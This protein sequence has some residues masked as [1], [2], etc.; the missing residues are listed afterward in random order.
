MQYSLAQI[1]I[2]PT[3][4]QSLP[5]KESEAITRKDSSEKIMKK[6]ILVFPCGSEIALEIHRSLKYSTYF[7]LIGGN[8]IDDHGRFVFENYIGDIPFITDSRFIPVIKEIVK[9]NNIAAIY[10]AMDAVIV[11]LKKYETDIGCKIISSDIETVELCLSKRKT[12]EKLKDIIKVPE[13]YHHAQVKKFPVFGKPD[14]GYG[15]RGTKK[16]DSQESLKDYIKNNKSALLCEFL[17]GEEYTV[18]CFTDKNGKLLFYAPRIRQR[19]MNGI[20]V[21]TIPYS[22]KI[23]EFDCIVQKINKAVK[24]R[25]AWFVQLKRNKENDLVLLEIAA[26]L[27]GSSSLFKA[28]GVNFAQLTLFDAF[29]YDVSILENAYSVELDRALDNVFKINI[30]YN[31]IFCDFDDCLIIEDKYV[32]TELISFLYQCFNE[33]KKITLLTRHENDIKNSLKTFRLHSIFDRIIHIDSIRRKS[34]YIDNVNSIFIDDSFSERKEVF[35]KLHIPVF[36][37]DMIS[38]LLK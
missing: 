37:V 1:R 31:E 17:Q 26:R 19:I 30:Q 9:K 16:I 27:G 38:C 25:G 23:E 6:N 24:F 4:R 8:S 13:I 18:D 15:S 29:D 11:K 3:L 5:A 34:D 12:Y 35:E 33:S 10:P 7:N 2:E 20:S 28:K 36:G 32:N 21:N 14:I 22:G